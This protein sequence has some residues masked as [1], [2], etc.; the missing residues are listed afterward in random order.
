MSLKYGLIKKNKFY[1][2]LCDMLELEE[3]SMNEPKDNQKVFDKLEKFI[4]KLKYIS[5]KGIDIDLDHEATSNDLLEQLMI[6]ITED[7]KGENMQGNSILLYS[8]ENY[9]FDVIYLEDLVN[10]QKE[11]DIN[12]LLTITNIN[13]E[14]I[15]HDGGIVKMSWK[16]GIP[17][18]ESLN[19]K[20]IY[21]I[22]LKTFY[23]TGIIIEPNGKMIELEYTGEDPFKVIGSG[24]VKGDICELFNLN[25]VLWVENSTTSDSKIKNKII[26]E[27]F[28]KDVYG[29][30][31]LTV[32][33]PV[34]N[35]RFWDINISTVNNFI[36]LLKDKEKVDKI[37]KDLNEE[38]G[39][40]SNP[41]FIIKKH[42]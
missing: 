18:Q 22:I 30:V 5:V 8:N 7:N 36:T 33:S 15:Y 10:E 3:I 25:F 14:P 27:L 17:T 40:I 34:Y 29:R 21:E 2:N 20:D 16:N 35:K 26:S 1:E 24:F 42:L 41:F 4:S 19:S 12:E 39:K 32:L 28:S 13:L 38:S 11:S 23:H 9:S 37:Y 6:D 31:F